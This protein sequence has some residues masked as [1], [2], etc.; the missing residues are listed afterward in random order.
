[1]KKPHKQDL[2]ADPVRNKTFQSAVLVTG[3]F[4]LGHFGLVTF[5]SDY[6]ILQKTYM[7]TF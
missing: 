7:F 2:R 4:C 3:L 5:R 1:M 6:E